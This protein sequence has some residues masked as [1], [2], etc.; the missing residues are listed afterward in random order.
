VKL[1][2]GGIVVEP[3][4]TKDVEDPL[5]VVGATPDTYVSSVTVSWAQA[6]PGITVSIVTI[7]KATTRRRAR[8]VLIGPLHRVV[9]LWSSFLLVQHYIFKTGKGRS[10]KI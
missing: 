10:V 3:C 4:T 7:V 2:L 8:V 5:A 9:K 1:G 6:V